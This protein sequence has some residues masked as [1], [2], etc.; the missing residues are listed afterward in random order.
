MGHP[1]RMN[2]IHIAYEGFVVVGC[3]GGVIA[4]ILWISSKRWLHAALWTRAVFCIVLAAAVT[5]SGLPLL[6]GVV[7]APALLTLLALL[8][9]GGKNSAYG[10]LYG[11]LPILLLATAFLSLWSLSL[12]RR[13]AHASRVA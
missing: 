12:R 10:V 9:D 5:P 8:P 6:G 2:S 4:T 3:I 13:A 7:V 11:A 1:T